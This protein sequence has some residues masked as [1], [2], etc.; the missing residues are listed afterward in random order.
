MKKSLAPLAVLSLTFS[1]AAQATTSVKPI[2]DS[3]AILESSFSRQLRTNA[4]GD[5]LEKI[6]VRSEAPKNWYNLSPSED[7]VEGVGTERAYRHFGSPAAEII[8]AVIDSGVD[9]NHEDLQGK[10]WMNEGE[11]PNNGIDDDNNGYVDD[12]FGW[13]FIGN[14]KGMATMEPSDNLNGLKLIKGDPALQVD[15]DTLEMTREVVRLKKLKKE[16][17]AIGYFLTEEERLK[18]E[19]LSADVEYEQFRANQALAQISKMVV[20]FKSA[21]AVLTA[22]GVLEI[23][24]EAVK[25][26][27]PA[28]AEQEEARKTMIILL[29]QGYDEAGLDEARVYYEGKAKYHYNTESDTRKEI[30]KD[31]I[32]N[33]EER[34]YGNNDVI[35]P[36]SSHGTHVAGTI[37]ASRDNGIGTKGVADNVKIMAIRAV[38]NGDERDKDVA[39]SIYYAVDNG[40]RIINMSFGKAHSPYKAVVDKALEYAESK[41]VLMVHAAGNSAQSNDTEPNFPNKKLEGRVANNWIE[42]GASAFKKGPSL[43]ASFS[44]FGKNSVDI[45][46]PGHNIHAPFPDNAYKTIS[47]TSM[48]SPVVAGIA[49]ALMGHYPELGAAEVKEAILGTSTRYPSLSV[50]KRGIGRVF[51]A[52][53]SATGGV[54]N[55]YNALEHMYSNAQVPFRVELADY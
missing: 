47:G 20:T 45:F 6:N 35:G 41:G 33:K 54:A 49:G 51:F 15:S 37:A 2:Y 5:I 12:V 11:I 1:I 7:E 18:L 44:N 50:Y 29:A 32:D 24:S 16:L 38:P 14:E 31:D 10:V 19:K 8:V 36:D 21:K 52:E 3:S 53:L 26:F 48:A 28:N 13:N 22:A 55:L 25:A 46:A 43:P 34:V 30:V 40:A 39:N 23:S 27:E 9:V 42:V 4:K 17:N